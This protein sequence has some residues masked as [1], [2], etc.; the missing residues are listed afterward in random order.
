L[1]IDNNSYDDDFKID[2]LVKQVSTL[3]DETFRTKDNLTNLK[4]KNVTCIGGTCDHFHSGHK[5]FFASAALNTNKLLCGLTNKFMLAKKEFSDV[6]E[7]APMRKNSAN[8]FFKLFD[9][10]LEVEV[11]ELKDGYGPIDRADLD[12]IILTPE[13]LKGGEA[14]NKKRAE[15]YNLGPLDFVMVPLVID[16]EIGDK[17][18][19]TYF[20]KYISHKIKLENG[21]KV[22]KDSWAFIKET[23]YSEP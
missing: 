19:S 11:F 16:E 17:T 18:S 20:R 10:T 23:L 12:S 13:T 8:N 7:E 6:L 1:P 21:I 14:C 5:M 15:C 9:K 4:E 22:L 2:H 3:I